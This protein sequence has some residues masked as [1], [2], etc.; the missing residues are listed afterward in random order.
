MKKINLHNYEAYLLDFFEGTI[1]KDDLAE[2]KQF[3]VLRPQLEVDLSELELP[4]L[5]EETTSADF[6]LDLKKTEIIF[7]EEHI[8]SYTE[9]LLSEAE[10][11]AIEEKA[12]VDKNLSKEIA[13]YKK[14]YFGIGESDNFE[15]KNILYKTED[16]LVLSN[17]CI[18]YIENQ[19]SETE[20][21]AF[22]NELNSNLSLQKELRLF[23][24][25]K[26]RADY[27][28]VYENKNELKKETKIIAL[29]TLPRILSVAASIAL[30]FVLGVLVIGNN[31]LK[32]GSSL[33][34]LAANKIIFK[35][36][37]STKKFD[38]YN[39]YFNNSSNNISQN[40]NKFVANIT[41][42]N[43][44]IKTYTAPSSNNNQIASSETLSPV[45]NFSVALTSN[46]ITSNNSQSNEFQPVKGDSSIVVE[47]KT[48]LVQVLPEERD[49]DENDV[50]VAPNSG[51]KTFWKKAV[52][53]AKNANSL[54]LTAINGKEANG[55]ALSFNSLGLSIK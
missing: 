29:F 41:P 42:T 25:T 36:P 53:L 55:Y 23:E 54:G 14:T 27:R 45:T 50:K 48:Y 11:K 15:I 3:L 22:E 16:D 13:A 46:T 28:N 26:Q 43:S 47:E 52:K 4:Y 30:I 44:I 18:A 1:S 20:K 7:S 51:K 10:T 24:L 33:E 12:L 34:R 40:K 49:D 9:G 38:S 35:E 2:L 37:N 31:D 21:I 39:T 19:L 8:I 17:N 5:P 32:N 6:I